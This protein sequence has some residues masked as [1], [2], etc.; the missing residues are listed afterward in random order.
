MNR[1]GWRAW[2]AAFALLALGA[3]LGITVDR[4]HVRGGGHGPGL[5]EQVRR[6]PVAYMD[7]ELTLRPEQR[8]RIAA[9]F[10]RHQGE[11]DTVWQ[12]THNRLIAAIDSLVAEISAELD[13]TQ[14]P[15]FNA[16]VKKLH[17]SPDFP[18]RPH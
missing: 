10:E 5:H 7:R 4:F 1:L 6:D 8:T 17:S 13:S 3:V 16:L 14:I 2:V 12:D 9:I 18:Y 11:I 15:R